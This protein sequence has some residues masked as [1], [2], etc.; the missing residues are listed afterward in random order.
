MQRKLFHFGIIYWAIFCVVVVTASYREGRA[1]LD[2]S[3]RVKGEVT[4]EVWTLDPVQREEVLRPQIRYP[5]GDSTYFYVDHNN[6]LKIGERPEIL[7]YPSNPEAAQVY[8]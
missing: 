5:V 6:A 3:V 1:I 8:N 2:K 7:Y 4:D